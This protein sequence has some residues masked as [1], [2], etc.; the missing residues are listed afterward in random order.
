MGN[1]VQPPDALSQPSAGA[2][3]EGGDETIFGP[4]R[5]QGTACIKWKQSLF[6]LRNNAHH[7]AFSATQVGDHGHIYTGWSLC[8]SLN[9]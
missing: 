4:A 9:C 2:Q 8:T 1:L 6:K 5:H 3:E 7:R